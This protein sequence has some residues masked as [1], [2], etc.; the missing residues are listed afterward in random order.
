MAGE[1]SRTTTRPLFFYGYV[2]VFVAI[3]VFMMTFGAN[4][5][6]GVFFKPLSTEFGWTKA[7]TSSAYSILTIS[8]GF[9]GIF[10]GRLTDR[11]SVRIVSIVM[12]CFLGIGYILMSQINAIWQMYLI[13]ALIIAPGLG[14]VWPAL[15]SIVPRWFALRRGL[16]MGVAASGVGIGTLVLPPVISRFIPVYGW[17]T[18]Y[19]IMGAFALTVIVLASLFLKRDPHQTGQPLY[20][21]DKLKP[22]RKPPETGTLSLRQVVRSHLFWM[23]CLIYF[24]FGFS[25]HTIMVHIVPHA[26][27]TGIQPETAAELLGIIGATTVVSKLVVGSVSDRLGIKLSLVYNFILLTAG[28][29]WLQAATDLWTLRGFAIA[30]GFSYGGIMTLQSLLAAELFGLSSLGLIVGCVSFIYTIG[31]ATGPVL[32]GYIFDVTGSYKVAFLICAILEAAALTVVLTTLGKR[33]S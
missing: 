2:I 33:K 6:F 3:I 13:Y 31:S 24:L 28:L 32:S 16:M 27:E 14:G 15:T 23:V 9:L 22:D 17:R 19:I 8:A 7:V 18:S 21:E 26:I 4:Y 20:G 29:L 12:G 1:T 11:F 25:L 30:F 5:T 10:A